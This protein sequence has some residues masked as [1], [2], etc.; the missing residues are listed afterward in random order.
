MAINLYGT[1]YFKDALAGTL[2]QIPDGRYAFTY[3]PAYIEA[4]RPQIAHTLSRRFAA[5]YSHGLHP[6]FDNLVA[7][8]WLARAQARALGIRGDDRFARLL[9][10]GEDFPGAASIRDPRPAREPDLDVGTREE[11]AALANRASISGV[12][13]KLLAVH[14]AHGFR[15]AAAGELSTHIAKLPSL[16]LGELVEL[17]YLTTVAA[18]TLLPDDVVVEL[19]IAEVE[20]IH[21][22]CLLV[23]RFDRT[24]S[25]HKVHFEEFNQLLDRPADAKYEGSYDEM[26]MFILRHQSYHREEDVDRLFRRILVCILLGNNDAHMKNFGLLYT[27]DGSRLAPFY[28]VVAAALYPEYKGSLALRLGAGKNPLDL[29]SLGPKH[30]S[31]L[32]ESFKLSPNAMELAVADLNR[33]LAVAMRAIEESAHGSK[34]LKEKLIEFMRKR[35]NGTFNSIGKQYRRRHDDEGRREA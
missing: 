27:A 11:I 12:Q 9:A 6:F 33:R 35:W 19:E 15:P 4:G 30:L 20:N 14:S 34:A 24:P 13:R 29:A 28:D 25:G 16:S 7:E 31:A 22:P 18:S 1:V 10:F 2:E 32:T 5:H 26:A 17:E 8:G 3:D 21:G 23:R